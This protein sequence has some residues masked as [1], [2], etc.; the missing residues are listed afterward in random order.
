M[1]RKTYEILTKKV[2]L[3][4]INS[5]GEKEKNSA[6]VGWE[7]TP[8]E[9][10]ERYVIYLGKGRV[11]KTTPVMDVKETHYALMIKTSNSIYRI[12]YL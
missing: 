12:E 10:G 7:F 8:P 2:M 9:V 6:V 1:L 11:L 3:V 4:K 5:K